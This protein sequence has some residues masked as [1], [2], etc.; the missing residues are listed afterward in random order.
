M[1]VFTS[2][3]PVILAVLSAT[4][5]QANALGCYKRGLNFDGLHG[6]HQDNYREVADDINTTCNMVANKE[7]R[8]GEPG[9][10]H[11]SQWAITRSAHEDCFDNCEAGCGALPRE[12]N[13]FLCSSGCDPNCDPGP[14]PGNNHINWVINLA[15]PSKMMTWEICS[16]AF[17]TELNGCPNGSEQNHEGFFFKIDAEVGNC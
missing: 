15:G 8:T 12:L 1:T 13:K 5:P 7:F 2:F 17:V 3:L 6:G 10:A 11:C 16:K 14:E 4:L 9:F